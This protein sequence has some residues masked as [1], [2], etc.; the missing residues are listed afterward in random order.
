MPR[1]VTVLRCH[2]RCLEHPE[3]RQFFNV[4][5]HNRCDRSNSGSGNTSRGR[6]TNLIEPVE[7]MGDHT[8][9]ADR[10]FDH[11]TISAR[12]SKRFV[13]LGLVDLG[14]GDLGLVGVRLDRSGV[15]R[16]GVN[17]GS[18]LGEAHLKDHST[19]VRE[20]V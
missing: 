10:R 16:S 6:D 15:D 17:C 19:T 3:S 18:G 7:Q 1:Y 5:Q 13:D 8:V 20:G 14:L 4:E 2:A 12:D 11:P 9:V